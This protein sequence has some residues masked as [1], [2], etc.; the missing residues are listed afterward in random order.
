MGFMD[1]LKSLFGGSG[2]GGDGKAISGEERQQ[3]RNA[4]VQGLDEV[5]GAENI[6][7]HGEGEGSR[8]LRSSDGADL[9]EDDGEKLWTSRINTEVAPQAWRDDWGPLGGKSPEALAT[10]LYH[11]TQFNMAQQGDADEGE[12]VLL[13]FGYKSVGQ[14]FRARITVLKHFGTPHGATLDEFVFDSQEV[15]SASMKAAQM[16]HQQTMKATAAKNPELLAPVDGVSV[17]LYAQIAARIASGGLNQ[18][19]M[20]Q[21]LAQH[22]L[23]YPTWD[24]AQKVWCD[25]MSKDTTATIATIY[26]QAFQQSG[27]GQF[28]AAGQA[29]AATGYDGT[30]AGGKEPIPFE[31]LCE[32]QGAMTAWSNSGQDV[33]ALLKKQ[34]NMNA[35][36]WSNA[37]TWWMSQMTANVS[38]F[39]QYNSKCEAYAARYQSAA[40]KPRHD[41]IKF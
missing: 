29:S 13:G 36:D 21:L 3:I 32:I 40:P 19:Q 10:F 28:G 14:F 25:R 4:A 33:N 26:G 5:E 23:D 17:E 20:M 27:Q 9:I 8:V 11:E 12:R 37:S 24:K 39:D 2:E 31:K 34:F 1:W 15:M 7:V 41:D 35:M 18:Q 22:N 38:M 30:A 16:G 6:H